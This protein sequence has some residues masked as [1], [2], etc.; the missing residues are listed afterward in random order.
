MNGLRVCGIYI[1]WSFIQ[2]Q[3]RMKCYHLQVNGWNW[4]HHLSKV[5]QV[6]KATYFL[7]YMEYKPNANYQ[8]YYKK[9]V[10]PRGGHLWKREGKR[11]K[12]GRLIWSMYFLYKNDYRIFKPVE[13]IIRGLGWKGEK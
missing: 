8:K 5:S 3:R 2:S 13:I 9:Q 1:Q 11:R 10:T 12:L 4:R 6:Q 7:S